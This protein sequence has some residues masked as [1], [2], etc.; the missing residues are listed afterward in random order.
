MVRALFR[1][2]SILTSLSVLGSGNPRRIGTHIVRRQAVKAL[3][4]RL[5][6]N[7]R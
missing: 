4:S 5:R 7:L 2:A 1:L 3:G 6:R